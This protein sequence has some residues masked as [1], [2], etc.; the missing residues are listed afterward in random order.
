MN[1]VVVTLAHNA[2]LLLATMV[3]FDLA[4]SQ[5]HTDIRWPRKVLAGVMLGA[6]SV[7]L[8]MTSF[9]LEDGI[10]FDTRSVLLSVSGLFLGPITTLVAMLLAAAYRIWLGGSAMWTGVLVIFATGTIGLIWRRYRP[11]RLAAISVLELLIFGLLVHLVMLGLMLTIPGGSGLQVLSAIAMPVLLVYPVATVALGML[12]AA[13]LKRQDLAVSLAQSETR[14]RSVFEAANVGKFLMSPDGDLDPNQSLSELLG[15]DVSELRRIPLQVLL[16]TEEREA[17]D[18]RLALLL[19]GDEETVRFETRMIHR[20]GSA[21]WVDGSISLL[22]DEQATPLYYIGTIFDISDR[23]RAE[24]KQ[25]RSEARFRIAQDIGPDGFTILRPIRNVQCEIVD[26]V[27]EYENHAVAKTNGTDPEAVIG[28]RLLDVFPEHCGSDLF[29]IYRHVA[30]TGE[31][32]V[33]DDVSIEDVISKP[34]WLRLVVV[35]MGDEIAILSQDITDRK[36]SEAEIHRLAYYDSLTNLPN[37]RLL[38]ERLCLAM[39]NSRRSGRHGALIFLD[40]D[41]FKTLNDTRGHDVGDQLLIEIAR[42]LGSEMRDTDTVARLGGDEFMVMLEGLDRVPDDAALQSRQ[43]A[44][45]IRTRLAHTYEMAAGDYHGSA[46]IGVTLFRGHEDSVE[47]LFKQADLALYRAKDSGRNAVRF[48]DPEMQTAIEQRFALE[49]DLRLALAANQFE[50][51]YQA[52]IDEAGALTGAEA[53]LRWR[54]PERGMVAPDDFIPL[55]ESA[56][57]IVDIGRWV[58]ESACHQLAAW[59]RHDSSRELQLAVNV[60]AREFRDPGFLEHV[61]AILKQT[62]ADPKHIRMELTESMVLDNIAEN[63]EK[64][65]GLQS[66][67]IGFALDDF[68]VG[69]SSLSYLTQLPLDTL[70]ID[71]SFVTHLPDSHN[72]AVIAQ[73]IISMSKSLG[74]KVIAEGV[75]TQAQRDFLAQHGCSIYQGYLLGRPMPRDDFEQTYGLGLN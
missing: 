18:Q 73:T 57:L 59:S 6:L 16:P 53:L 13:R 3:V 35:P 41:Q 25:R 72:D 34:I 65:Q 1:A 5:S 75:E 45:K 42:R 20:D 74:L 69:Y 43:I 63:L 37:R 52:Q 21:I 31:Y 11:G 40:L 51:Y 50:L 56:G 26:F 62:G 47:T 7:G 46:S 24:E 10:I 38:Q 49:V 39:A 48:F 36:Q 9:Q 17:M 12:L 28:K 54:H 44:E 15:H 23:K 2:A 61:K 58:F 33:I 68:G 60:S 70:K 67:G 19:A 71:R 8:M 27:W 29:E 4:T 22:R 64:M 66:L 32:R 30:E 14:Y 55:A